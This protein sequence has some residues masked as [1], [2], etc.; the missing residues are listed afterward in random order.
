MF[1]ASALTPGAVVAQPAMAVLP[2]VAGSSD[3]SLSSTAG[4]HNR[5]LATMSVVHAGPIQYP[6]RFAHAC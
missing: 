4:Q 2:P 3:Y 5:P 1:L 6:S